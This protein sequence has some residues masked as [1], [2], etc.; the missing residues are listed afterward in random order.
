MA[1]LSRTRSHVQGN[2]DLRP[3]RRALLDG[4]GRPVVDTAVDLSERPLVEGPQSGYLMTGDE[5]RG[6]HLQQVSKLHELLVGKTCGTEEASAKFH[7][8]GTYQIIN[9]QSPAREKHA[10]VRENMQPAV[11]CMLLPSPF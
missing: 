10:G 5:G 1:I 4:H 3:V 8:C 11:I 9:L 2:T 6:H 7:L